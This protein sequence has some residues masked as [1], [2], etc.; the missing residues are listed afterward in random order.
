MFSFEAPSFDQMVKRTFV[1]S[2]P[3]PLP[4]KMNCCLEG[5]SLK[6]TKIDA[7]IEEA[8]LTFGGG[9]HEKVTLF[10]FIATKLL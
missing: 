2:I 4:S 3:L 1:V 8:A 6:N 10:Y 7:K 9:V 5:R